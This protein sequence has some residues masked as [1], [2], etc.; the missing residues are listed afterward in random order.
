MHLLAGWEQ[1]A[2]EVGPPLLNQDAHL[3]IDFQYVARQQ[4]LMQ[5]VKLVRVKHIGAA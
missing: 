5:G 2:G 4:A 3:V 1:F